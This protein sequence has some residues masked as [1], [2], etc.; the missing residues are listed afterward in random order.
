MILRHD[1]AAKETRPTANSSEADKG[2]SQEV[3]MKTFREVVVA[4]VSIAE[5]SAVVVSVVAVEGAAK[6][7][8]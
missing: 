4:A 5:A 8:T 3:A 1:L 6:P 7:S 2:L